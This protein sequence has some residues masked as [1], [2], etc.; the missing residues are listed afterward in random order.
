M[1]YVH[2]SLIRYVFCLNENI[3]VTVTH[4]HSDSIM[5]QGGRGIQTG[6]VFSHIQSGP[7]REQEDNS[8]LKCKSTLRHASG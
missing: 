4:H 2:V 7:G 5:Y 3:H 1:F 8:L 6:G